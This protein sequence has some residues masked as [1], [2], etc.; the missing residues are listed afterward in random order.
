VEPPAAG[1]VV[2]L[3]AGV[4]VAVVGVAL[5]ADVLLRSGNVLVVPHPLAAQHTASPTSAAAARA[6]RRRLSTSTRIALSD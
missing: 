3:V 6:T 2:A 5:V 1:V 4:V